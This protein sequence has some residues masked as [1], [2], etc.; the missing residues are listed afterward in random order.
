MNDDLEKLKEEVKQLK[1]RMTI[2]EDVALK[3]KEI[4]NLEEMAVLLG[5]KKGTLYQLTH[6]NA[7]PFSRPNGRLIFFERS[8]ILEWLRNHE[9]P[10]DEIFMTANPRAVLARMAKE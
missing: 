3:N 10:M 1:H 9:V 7:I 5:Y 4:L 8:R 2:L 6:L